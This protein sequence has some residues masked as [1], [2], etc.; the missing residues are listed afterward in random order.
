MHNDLKKFIEKNFFE[1]DATRIKRAFALI[2]CKMGL[3]NT[4][5][6]VD[7]SVSLRIDREKF[8]LRLSWREPTTRDTLS[9]RD[10][11]L[12][13]EAYLTLKLKGMWP[14]NMKVI[15]PYKIVGLDEIEMDKEDALTELLDAIGIHI[16]ELDDLNEEDI[17]EGSD[18]AKAKELLKE[19]YEI[20]EIK[21][22]VFDTLRDIEKI[23]KTY[24]Y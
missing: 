9:P 16:T 22:N 2:I 20:Y 18:T 6:F 7:T 17:E 19:L 3:F 1:K 21:D 10:W 5:A 11:M 12:D 23:I 14:A 24:V 4:D 13:F 8:I 15:P